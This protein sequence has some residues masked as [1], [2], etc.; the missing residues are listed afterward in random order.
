MHLCTVTIR[1]YS[2]KFNQKGKNKQPKLNTADQQIS[3]DDYTI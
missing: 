3:A 1:Y 2:Q